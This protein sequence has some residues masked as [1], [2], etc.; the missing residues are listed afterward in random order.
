MALPPMASE[1]A[2]ERAPTAA[3]RVIAEEAAAAE[4]SHVAEA[5]AAA[6]EAARAMAEQAA[7]AETARVMAEEAAA[8]EAARVM[9]AEAFSALGRTDLYDPPT[10]LEL[11]DGHLTSAKIARK[12]RRGRLDSRLEVLDKE[13]EDEADAEAMAERRTEDQPEHP[14][15]SAHR[16][17][18]GAY[19]ELGENHVLWPGHEKAKE[20]AIEEA[21]KQEGYSDEYEPP[22]AV[23]LDRQRLAL[24]KNS[25]RKR[26]SRL[27]RRLDAVRKGRAKVVKQAR[28][29]E[30]AA[31]AASVL[32]AL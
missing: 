19:L 14:M 17:A 10:G 2:E 22:V 24:A 27:A 31:S 13:G 3:A 1:A 20:K 15:R 6:D 32:L 4:A 21:F 28:A 29:K 30:V 9:A 12:R 18:A 25:R 5:Q 26:R 23:E 8:L 7:A 16:A 11:S